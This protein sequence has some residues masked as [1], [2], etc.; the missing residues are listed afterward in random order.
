MALQWTGINMWVGG[1]GGQGE[2]GSPSPH[3]PSSLLVLIKGMCLPKLRPRQ[4][5]LSHLT[6]QRLQ[7]FF[8]V[9]VFPSLFTTSPPLPPSSLAQWSGWPCR[10]LGEADCQH[11]LRMLE[12]ERPGEK[13]CVASFF[14][15][16]HFL[17]WEDDFAK[18]KYEVRSQGILVWFG[19]W[20]TQF[21][22][23]SMGHTNS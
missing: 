1:T 13:T 2:G 16:S 22:D 14:L 23:V 12:G 8:M 21:Q 5:S 4:T 6:W 18:N 11:L 7:Q 17:K 10:G 3:S 15:H 9:F 20:T 19:T